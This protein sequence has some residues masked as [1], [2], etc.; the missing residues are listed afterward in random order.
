ME[1]ALKSTTDSAWVIHE[2]GYEPLR[3]R[4]VESRLSIGNGL[5]GVRGVPT[6]CGEDVCASWPRT[7]V[8]GLSQT[9]N[10]PPSISTL[11]SA[12]D[13][14]RVT[15]LVNGESPIRR[16][17]DMVSHRRSLDMRRGA[18]LSTWHPPEAASAVVR[19]RSLRLVSLVDRGAA[20]QILCIDMGEEAE[21]TL[22]VSCV[23]SDSALELALLARDL[24]VWRISKTGKSLAVAT[25]AVLQLDGREL[26]PLA[27]DK[28]K[29]RWHWKSRPGQIVYFKRLVSFARSDNNGDDPGRVARE[30][31]GNLQRIG[32]REII[33]CHEAAWDE[34][35]RCSEVQVEGDEAAQRSLRFAAYHLNSAQ[36]Q[37]MNS[38]PLVQEP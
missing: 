29:W 3:E 14:V 5:L 22:E 35:W 19:V 23:A 12:P 31:L 15:I 33:Q 30:T 13:W 37:L 18:L 7:Y 8:A 28:L 11:V 26:P 32:W 2:H 1:N 10:I 20:L 4:G 36:T 24:G 6:I 27:L 25:A 16:P 17:G 9:P 38:S 21:I 34:R